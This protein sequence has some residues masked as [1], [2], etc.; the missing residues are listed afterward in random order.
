V[1]EPPGYHVGDLQIILFQHDHVPVA[2][3]AVVAEAQ[4][5]N[6]YTGLR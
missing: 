2:V 3:D 1:A 5:G 4:R 6:L